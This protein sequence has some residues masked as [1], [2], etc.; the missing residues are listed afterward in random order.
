[1]SSPCMCGHPRKQHLFGATRCRACTC[2]SYV[3]APLNDAVV[4]EPMQVPATEVL[5][6]ADGWQPSPPDE[7]PADITAPKDAEPLEDPIAEL[8]QMLNEAHIY[9]RFYSHYSMCEA[10]APVVKRIEDRLYQLADERRVTHN[11]VKAAI[12]AIDLGA[13]QQ[14]RALLVAALAEPKKAPT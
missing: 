3:A 11:A 5:P 13:H 10:D 14:A 12:G 2:R 4:P 9:P 8:E 1:M 7:A 6:L